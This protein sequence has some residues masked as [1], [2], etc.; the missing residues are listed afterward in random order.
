MLLLRSVTDA[1]FENF[2]GIHIN[3]QSPS[4]F[5]MSLYFPHVI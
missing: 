1:G 2:S 5:H 3:E 4:Y